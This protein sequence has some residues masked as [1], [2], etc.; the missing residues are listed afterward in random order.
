VKRIRGL[1]DFS[2]MR[3]EKKCRDSFSPEHA[4]FSRA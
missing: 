3:H 1:G 2:V 4:R